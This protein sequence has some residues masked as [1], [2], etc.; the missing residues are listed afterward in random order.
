M[1]NDSRTPGGSHAKDSL[2]VEGLAAIMQWSGEAPPLYREIV[3]KCYNPNRAL[4]SPFAKYMW[5]L[6]QALHVLEPFPSQMVFRG[7]KLDLSRDYPKDWAL[8]IPQSQVCF[9]V[10]PCWHVA[11]TEIA[12]LLFD[13]LV[14]R[15]WHEVRVDVSREPCPGR[16]GSFHG[17]GP[18]AAQS[19]SQRS[20]TRSSWAPR[21]HGRSS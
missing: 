10:R 14:P 2:D 20:R 9:A 13:S 21:G 5:L 7:V 4:F 16:T 15:E 3:E 19:P 11:I 8:L 12:K 1:A 18:A 17:M 6:M